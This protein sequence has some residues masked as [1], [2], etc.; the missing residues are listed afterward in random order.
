MEMT[1]FFKTT[2]FSLIVSCLLAN[3]AVHGDGFPWRKHAQRSADWYQSPDG[4]RLIENVLSH[5]APNGSWP[6]NIDTGADRFRGDSR[7]LRGTFDNGAT[8]GELRFLA[9]AYQL[10]QNE[11]CLTA[12]QR[13]LDLILTAQY[14]NGGWPQSYPPGSGYGRYITFNDG[15]MIGILEFL[16]DVTESEDFEFVD[17]KR[18]ARANRAVEKGIDC[19]LQCQIVVNGERTAWCAQHDDVTLVPQKA[20]SYEH[21]SISGGEGAGICLFLM[22]IEDPSLQVIDAVNASCRWF[23]KAQIRNTRVERRDGDKVVAADPDAPPIWARFYEIETNRPIFSGRDGV[24][25]YSLSEIEHERRNG[26]SWYGSS[27]RKVLDAWPKRIA[28]RSGSE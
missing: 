22:S 9:R 25:K 3:Q 12:F 11:E 24:I 16:R 13:G 10:T 17:S 7:E 21:P 14:P 18:R 2:C 6:K 1:G 15:A 26:Y 28:R 19:I 23:E 27:G 5:Q 4:Q 8:R 20:R